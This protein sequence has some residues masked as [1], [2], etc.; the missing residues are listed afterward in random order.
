MEKGLRDFTRAS[1]TRRSCHYI[2]LPSLTLSKRQA[3]LRGK[4]CKAARQF[5]GIAVGSSECDRPAWKSIGSCFSICLRT[6]CALHFRGFWAA[7]G[8]GIR[9][10]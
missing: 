9:A 4:P 3:G 5:N 6:V 2:G 7:C 10:R 8:Q 1:P